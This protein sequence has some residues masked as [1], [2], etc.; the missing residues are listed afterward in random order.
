MSR[1]TKPSA[2][3]PRGI[4]RVLACALVEGIVDAVED[5]CRQELAA[6]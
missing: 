5:Q 6:I 3:T 2:Q 4:R 1:L